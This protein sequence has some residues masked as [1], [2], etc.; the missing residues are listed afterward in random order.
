M[1]IGLA[2]TFCGNFFVDHGLLAMMLALFQGLLLLFVYTGLGA[3]T[4]RGAQTWELGY[5]DAMI[6][7][8]FATLIFV[9]QG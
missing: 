7:E 8:K 3:N 2:Q 4:K 6:T 1:R 9:D 5:H